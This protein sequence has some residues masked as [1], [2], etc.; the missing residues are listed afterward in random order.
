MRTLRPAEL[1]Q[2]KQPFCL[3]LCLCLCLSKQLDTLPS[4]R[5]RYC[6]HQFRFKNG[7][8]TWRKKE[9]AQLLLRATL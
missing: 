8:V 9:Q 5:Y 1:L 7:G 3:Y 4:T 6:V 2:P